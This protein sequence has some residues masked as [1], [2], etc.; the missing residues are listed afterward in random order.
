MIASRIMLQVLPHEISV[1]N[2]EHYTDL[3][4]EMGDWVEENNVDAPQEIGDAN[5]VSIYKR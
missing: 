3:E 5:M 4:A 2:K 1:A